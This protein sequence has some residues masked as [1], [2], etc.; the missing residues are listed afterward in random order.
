M[1]E[2]DWFVQEVSPDGVMLRGTRVDR[3]PGGIPGTAWWASVD[4]Q[5]WV[6][7]GTTTHED[8]E[9][10]FPNVPAALVEAGAVIFGWA[11]GEVASV[12]EAIERMGLSR[13]RQVE[14]IRLMDAET[15]ETIA[16]VDQGQ[17]DVDIEP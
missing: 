17:R 14:T 9:R 3:I 8:I 6:L 7:A 12:E 13:Y 16:Y 10:V 15:G 4:G 1:T 2:M 11:W 5:G